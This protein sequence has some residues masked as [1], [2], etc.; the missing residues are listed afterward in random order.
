MLKRL[1]LAWLLLMWPLFQFLP[2]APVAARPQYMLLGQNT[3]F[4]A[5]WSY[6]NGSA[7]YTTSGASKA[8]NLGFTPPAGAL[9]VCGAGWTSTSDTVSITDNS[10][11]PADT[12]TTVFPLTSFAG[13]YPGDYQAWAT[14]VTSGTRPT[15]VTVSITPTNAAIYVG[16]TAYAAP[17]GG[18]VQD[19][20]AVSTQLSSAGTSCAI[21]YT[22]GAAAGDLVWSFT[23][24]VATSTSLTVASPFAFRVTDTLY[25]QGLADDGTPGG[26]AASTGVTA[27]YTWT[28]STESAGCAA[29]G[30]KW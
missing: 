29:V 22:T 25:R 17:P 19:G 24:I 9:L 30:F 2:A 4:G 12:W 15:T 8:L 18:L 28:A 23:I 21:T 1:F 3:T 26:V 10:S 13:T 16:C 6:I 7:A 27:T 20:S 14:I 11:G 5:N